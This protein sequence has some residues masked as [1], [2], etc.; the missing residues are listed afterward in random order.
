MSL[1]YIVMSILLKHAL[2]LK[3]TVTCRRKCNASILVEVLIYDENGIVAM[4]YYSKNI[5]D[6]MGI[7]INRSKWRLHVNALNDMKM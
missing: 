3:I 5:P 1:K 4:M 6:S 2:C 7:W